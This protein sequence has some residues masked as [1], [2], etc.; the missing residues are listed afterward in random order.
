[1]LGGTVLGLPLLSPLGVYRSGGSKK[2]PCALPSKQPG[3]DSVLTAYTRLSDG[4]NLK[5]E[6]IFFYIYILVFSNFADI[7]PHAETL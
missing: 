1:M 3:V 6:S 5:S 4:S 2:V 7:T